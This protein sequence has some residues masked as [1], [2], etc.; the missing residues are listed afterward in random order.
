MQLFEL[1]AEPRGD[2]GKGAAA[3]AATVNCRES[4][5]APKKRLHLSRSTIAMSFI[6][7]ETKR[8]IHES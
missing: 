6:N 8:F 7:W 2:V 4:S 5:M 3:C 1:N